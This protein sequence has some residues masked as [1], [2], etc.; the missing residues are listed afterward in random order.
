M[1]TKIIEEFFDKSTKTKKKIAVVGDCLIDEYFQ[2]TSERISPEFPIQIF[3][4]PNEKPIKVVPGGAA[5]VIR[6]FQNLNAE[7]KLVSIIDDYSYFVFNKS[8]NVDCCRPHWNAQ[9]PIKKRF[10]HGE[11]P[12]IRWDCESKNF[13]LNDEELK[14]CHSDLKIPNIHHHFSSDIRQT[15]LNCHLFVYGILMVFRL[16][17]ST[18]TPKC[19]LVAMRLFVQQWCAS[20]QQIHH[21]LRKS[22][23]S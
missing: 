16:P 17:Q 18:H 23:P 13:N 4:S 8:I 1:Q 5:N 9:I 7:T 6:Q 2:I 19:A 20:R 12:L 3:N 22:D 14:E 15:P 10:Y 11:F 21:G